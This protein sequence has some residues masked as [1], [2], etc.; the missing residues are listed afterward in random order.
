[1]SE[2]CDKRVCDDCECDQEDLFKEPESDTTLCDFSQ[3]PNLGNSK[4]VKRWKISK[5]AI[6]AEVDAS[7]SLQVMVI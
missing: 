5:E 7:L 6:Y 4:E 1:M 2:S 3:E